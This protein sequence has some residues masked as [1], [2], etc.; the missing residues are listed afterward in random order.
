MKIQDI[1]KLAIKMGVDSDF[2]G[3]EGVQK[4]LESKKKRFDKLVLYNVLLV[5]YWVRTSVCWVEKE[6]NLRR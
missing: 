2:R 6:Y 5:P 4:L 1:Q 3:K